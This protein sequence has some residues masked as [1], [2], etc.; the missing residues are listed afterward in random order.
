MI[1][2]EY[3]KKQKKKLID[4]ELV[5]YAAK[6]LSARRNSSHTVFIHFT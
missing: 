3:D 1:C 5:N 2:P 6:Q 4:Q